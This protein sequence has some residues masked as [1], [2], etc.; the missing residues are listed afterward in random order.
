M[1]VNTLNDRQLELYIIGNGFDLHHGIASAYNNFENYVEKKITT[2]IT[3]CA[4]TLTMIIRGVNLKRHLQK[5]ILNLLK[6]NAKRYCKP[7]F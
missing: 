7:G 4:H 5:L 1:T 2:C 6:K 3:V